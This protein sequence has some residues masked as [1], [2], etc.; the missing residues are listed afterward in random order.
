[1]TCKDREMQKQIRDYSRKARQGGRIMKVGYKKTQIN[2]KRYKWESDPGEK[3]E[4]QN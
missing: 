1:M 3:M 2:E 4:T